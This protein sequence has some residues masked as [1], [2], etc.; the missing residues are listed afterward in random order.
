MRLQISP[1]MRIRQMHL[2][3]PDIQQDSH[4]TNNVIYMGTIKYRSHGQ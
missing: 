4:S 3:A 1:Y 2:F